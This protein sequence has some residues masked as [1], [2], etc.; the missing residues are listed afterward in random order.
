M[1][2]LK[3]PVH[4]FDVAVLNRSTDQQQLLITNRRELLG[5]ALNGAVHFLQQPADSVSIFAA[6]GH[7]T[8]FPAQ[9]DQCLKSFGQGNITEL[10]P[11]CLLYTSDAADD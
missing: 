2:S 9:G 5:D 8:L 10:C 7:V 4:P 6:D 11:V 1:A 3:P